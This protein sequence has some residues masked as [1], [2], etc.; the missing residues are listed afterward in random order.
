ME[1]NQIME[2]IKE[3]IVFEYE[4]ITELLPMDEIKKTFVGSGYK[5]TSSYTVGGKHVSLKVIHKTKELIA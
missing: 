4:G 3:E 5:I 2:R 1:R